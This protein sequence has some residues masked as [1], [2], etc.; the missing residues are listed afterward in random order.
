MSLLGWSR[1]EDRDAGRGMAMALGEAGATVVCA[2]RTTCSHRSEHDRPETIEETAELVTQTW[3]RWRGQGPA[4][5]N[6][7]I[8]QRDLDNSLRILRW[9]ST[10]T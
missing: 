9:Q 3:Q 8:W 1:G 2:G 10:H 7:P 6:K 5:W 4:D